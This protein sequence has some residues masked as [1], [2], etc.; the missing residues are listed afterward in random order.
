M[1][2]TW[3]LERL[4]FG[5]SHDR[6]ARTL[7]EKNIRVVDWNDEWIET[8]NYPDLSNELVLF[9]GSLSNADFIFKS[10]LW[11]PGA[12]CNTEMFECLSWYEQV[13]K[14]IV[15][16]DWSYTT[17]EELVNNPNIYTSKIKGEKL[18]VRPNSP[19]K[20]FSGRVL[21]KDNVSLK[22]LDFGYYYDD[23]KEK[24]IISSQSN[25]GQE[26]RFV[27]CNSKVV[28]GSSYT[29]DNRVATDDEWKGKPLE[30][31]TEIASAIDPP[32]DVYVMDICSTDKGLKLLELNPF[33]GA[34]LYNCDR[35]SI[36]VAITNLLENARR[37]TTQTR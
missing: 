23:P 37:N 32:E 17:V 25:I 9:H 10:K 11:S 7:S 29:A 13:S 26:W 36:V 8:K 16:Q 20:P 27:I 30:L 34:D 3:I 31:A 1:K 4:V 15:Q 19:L 18:F 24:V 21:N 35:E 2:I 14:W 5:D 28:T 12:F 33:S 22:S 6:L